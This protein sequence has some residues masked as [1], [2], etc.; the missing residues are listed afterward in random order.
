MQPAFTTTLDGATFNVLEGL[1]FTPLTAAISV[2]PH[3]G[4]QAVAALNAS[5]SNLLI[6]V[7][8]SGFLMPLAKADREDDVQVQASLHATRGGASATQNFLAENVT[9]CRHACRLPLARTCVQAS[10]QLFSGLL[11]Q[12][13]SIL[14]RFS[15]GRLPGVIL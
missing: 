2:C 3:A 6:D 8:E 9:I 14:T 4:Q 12:A 1:N 11:W 7:L 13:Q 5:I 10:A 15:R